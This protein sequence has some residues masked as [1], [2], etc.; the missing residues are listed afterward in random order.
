MG[1]L[2]RTTRKILGLSSSPNVS[3]IK[4]VITLQKYLDRAYKKVK[5]DPDEKLGPDLGL[6]TCV[7]I[8][9]FLKS[10][11][12][13]H[14][15]AG[16]SDEIDGTVHHLDELECFSGSLPKVAAMF[17][18]FKL[19]AEA[20]SLAEQVKAGSVVITGTTDTLRLRDF[21]NKLEVK[22]HL[23]D[24][25][26]QI[27]GAANTQKK[28]LFEQ[29]LKITGSFAGGATLDVQF[30]DNFAEH[31]KK[32]IVPSDNC[33]AGECI[34]RLSYPYINVKLMEAGFF[35]KDLMKGI[36]LAGDYIL[37]GQPPQACFNQDK[38]QAY[39]RI[40]TINDCDQVTH[41][42]GSAQNTTSR[43]MAS[44]FF[45]ILLKELVDPNSSDEMR[46]LLEEARDGPDSSFL[47]VDPGTNRSTGTIPKQ[48]RI[49][50]VKIGQGPIK[51]DPGRGN[52]EVR[53]EGILIKWRGI[54]P[55]TEN[56]DPALKKKFDDLNLTGEGA[57]CWQN[58]SNA[59]PTDGIIEIINSAVSDFINQ[60]PLTP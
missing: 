32:M 33:S 21:F 59:T 1:S 14:E 60:A 12:A 31:M 54:T 18:A 8:S 36:W 5:T 28:P 13:G 27:S 34:F 45:K 25:L 16:L 56:F 7:P 43:Q 52:I 42:C 20:R 11:G 39:V 49:T 48:F 3:K 37:T 2:T 38:K 6:R 50:A 55:D 4:T 10:N 40:D 15:Y 47:S 44:F 23:G 19:R 17:A 35:N 22:I 57:I 29:I 30:T 53:S 9:I 46:E 24:A 58:F 41:F 26:P 51:R